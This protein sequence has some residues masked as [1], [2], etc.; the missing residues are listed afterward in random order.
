MTQY[1]DT[2]N[3]AEREG[4]DDLDPDLQLAR[5][6]VCFH[7]RSTDRIHPL[8][9]Y[10]HPSQDVQIFAD[11]LRTKGWDV[12]DGAPGLD[13]EMQV[14]VKAAL[15]CQADVATN[16]QAFHLDSLYDEEQERKR[17]EEA[18]QQLRS[19]AIAQG[20]AEFRA[21][22]SRRRANGDRSSGENTFF[23]QYGNHI[24]L[25]TVDE[26]EEWHWDHSSD[27]NYEHSSDME[28]EEL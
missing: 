2:P 6:M 10:P 25:V 18:E 24:E 26:L 28:Y 11:L 7:C 5:R 19:A 23:I 17:V 20:I 22:S 27:P 4:Y 9:S 1:F 12:E 3:P 21:N 15:K 16:A 8:S 13:P 14:R